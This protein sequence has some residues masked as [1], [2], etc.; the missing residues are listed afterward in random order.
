MS[1]PP[2]EKWP[3]ELKNIFDLAL[4]AEIVR[5]KQATGKASW[6]QTFFGLPKEPMSSNPIETQLAY[7]M[8]NAHIATKVKSVIS[9]KH[10]RS[11]Q[12]DS[13]RDFHIL[14]VSGGVSV[15]SADQLTKSI[16][17]NSSSELDDRL[18]NQTPDLQVQR[19]WWD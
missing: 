3:F 11:R 19:W 7:P 5:Q 12:P 6:E 4:V 18:K 16:I 15:S 10:L 17:Q 14:G 1:K 9:E 13:R 8:K 2:I